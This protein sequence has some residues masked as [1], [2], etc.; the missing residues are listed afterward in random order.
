MTATDHQHIPFNKLV[1]WK[2]NIRRKKGADTS[3]AEL[4][5]SIAANGLLQSLVV[6]KS[7]HGKYAVIAGGR[8]LKALTKLVKTGA[9]SASEKVP[10]RIINGDADAT[11]IGLAENAVREQ[12]HP[13]DEFDA[14]RK[15]ADGGMPLEDIAARFGITAAVVKKRL[16]LARVSPQ[17]VDAHRRGD[18]SLE[19]V[20]AFAVS[21][22]HA[23][24][25]HLLEECSFCDLHP[26]GIRAALTE[27][28]IAASDRRVKFIGLVSER[29]DC[30]TEPYRTC[31]HGGFNTPRTARSSANLASPK[32]G[33]M[34]SG[35]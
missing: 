16:K 29:R 2:D 22:D 21:D 4:S 10:C 30:R 18:L 32:R 20:I 28:E 33:L 6:R 17:I 14:F 24:Q 1:P 12:M 15:L 26:E 11:E 5:A 19:C 27:N 7:D 8:R 34:L 35:F 13:A 23:A 3:L 31:R 9:I 25:E